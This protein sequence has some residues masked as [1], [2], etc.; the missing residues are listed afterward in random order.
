[1]PHI[2]AE[3]RFA[4]GDLPSD[5]EGVYRLALLATDDEASARRIKMDVYR[6]RLEAKLVG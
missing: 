3:R 2:E 1:M 5:I 4:A 6:R